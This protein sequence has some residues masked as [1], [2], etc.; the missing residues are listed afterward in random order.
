MR[1]VSWDESRGRTSLYS[2][3]QETQADDTEDHASFF[4]VL[5]WGSLVVTAGEEPH[6]HRILLAQY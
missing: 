3:V 2:S 4:W 5:A 6:R 1:H